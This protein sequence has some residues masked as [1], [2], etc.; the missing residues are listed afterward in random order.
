VHTGGEGGAQGA[1]AYDTGQSGEFVR[2][3]R[4]RLCCTAVLIDGLGL[5]LKV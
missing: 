2:R 3:D 1:P 5:G 4:G